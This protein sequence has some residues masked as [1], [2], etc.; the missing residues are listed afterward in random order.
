MDLQLNAS[1]Y[2]FPANSSANLTSNISI[3]LTYT[4]SVFGSLLSL[5]NIQTGNGYTQKPNVFVRS[6][7]TSNVLPG[8]I[9]YSTSSNTVTGTNTQFTRYFS[10]NDCIF[11]QSNSTNGQ[12][13][14]YQIVK[15]VSNNTSLTLY[16]PPKHSSTATAQ[17][18]VAPVIL[19]AN[20]ALYENVMY[21]PDSTINGLNTIVEALPSTGNNVVGAVTAIDSGK[22]Y[23]DG[24]FVKMYLYGG[25]TTP[26]IE[27]GGTGYANN[28]KLVFSGSGQ[29]PA[30]G[31]ITTNA[32]GTIISTT[33]SYNGSGYKIPPIISVQTANGSGAILSTTVTE[34][35]TFSEVS[36]RVYK[37]GEGKGL[38]YWSTTRGFLNSD[39]YIQDSYFYQDF[40][41]Q[42]K[43][44][45]QLSKYKDILYNTFH[46]AGSALFGQYQVITK[47]SELQTI[48]YEQKQ[49]SIS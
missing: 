34:F 7:L 44:A 6:V 15:N 12:T 17:F 49:A 43:V 33:L 25:L 8:T 28:E 39:K 36:G 45:T 48:G 41:Y 14:E 40:S 22:G 23:I 35:N 2:N 3:A 19:P 42:I 29:N 38:G 31:F 26:T 27:N 1:Q 11:L 24:E 18:R 46:T 9:T 20:F 21:A 32:N 4:N 37:S 16:G 30:Q 10:N 5:S 47:T 13:I